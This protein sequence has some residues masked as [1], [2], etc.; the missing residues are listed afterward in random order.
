MARS[1]ELC[2]RLDSHWVSFASALKP[3]ARVIDLGCGSGAV[4][5]ALRGASPLSVTGVD[6]ARIPPAREPGFE[7]LANVRIESLPFSEAAFDAAVSQFGYEYA[8]PEAAAAE[9][10]RVLAPGASF[11]FLIH[12]P[13]GPIVSAMRRHRRAIEGLCGLRVQEAFFSG[14]ENALAER[15]ALLKRE[16]LDDSV[17]E[18]AEHGLNMQIRKDELA[19]LQVWKGVVQALAPELFMLDS[20][21]LCCTDDRSIDD[22]VEP[23]TRWFEVRPPQPL[24]SGNGEPIAWIVEGN[25]LP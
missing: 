21:G 4:G 20:L 17:V 2:E 16:C 5:R 15:I 25:R 18:Q 24:L 23:L 3:S 6:I 7:L 1:P 19:R 12:H 13:D 9:V 11:S 8:G 14:N 22:L 10:G